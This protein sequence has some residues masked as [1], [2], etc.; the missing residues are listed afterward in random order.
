MKTKVILIGLVIFLSSC[1]LTIIEPVYDDR[2]RVT[3]S[4]Q[5]EEH[6]QTYNDFTR[7]FISIHK[8]GSYD[9]V[10][11]ENFYNAGVN[12]RATVVY[13]KI[14]ISRQRVNGYEIEGIGTR[15]GN[16]ID[17]SYHVRDTYS[18]NNPTDYCSATAW[19]E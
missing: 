1:E 11:I 17:F 4:Y 9:E 19:F 16:E 10:I 15:Y 3:G 18:Y 6:S 7:Y 5:L 14:Y 13:D 12:V 2:D 8:T